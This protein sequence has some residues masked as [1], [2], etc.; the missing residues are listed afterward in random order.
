MAV[1]S[2][3][4]RQQEITGLTSFPGLPYNDMFI[5]DDNMNMNKWLL[6]L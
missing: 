5:K 4:Q 6:L 3:E 2:N 1:K